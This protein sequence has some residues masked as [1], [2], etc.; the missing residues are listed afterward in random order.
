MVSYEV[1]TLLL[2]LRLQWLLFLVV[3]EGLWGSH[4]SRLLLIWSEN[5]SLEF[6][7][8]VDYLFHHSYKNVNH[9]KL[10]VEIILK[11]GKQYPLKSE[12]E[13]LS[14]HKVFD[15]LDVGNSVSAFNY[16]G[17]LLNCCHKHLLN[18]LAMRMVD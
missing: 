12:I 18:R 9:D 15:R 10:S 6:D 14:V 1:V 4:C 7:F 13:S 8:L 5:L 11:L 16:S 2:L 3:C 17:N